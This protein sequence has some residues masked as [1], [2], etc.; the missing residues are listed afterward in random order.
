MVLLRP[1]PDEDYIFGWES[2]HSIN[3]AVL[4][5]PPDSPILTD[6]LALALSRPIVPPWFKRRLRVRQWGKW[7]FGRDTCLNAMPWGTIGPYALTHYAHKHGLAHK[8][9]PIEVFYPV[10][11][12]DAVVSL[13]DPVA[14]LKAITSNT[15]GVH[16]WHSKLALS[17]HLE[18]FEGCWLKEQCRRLGVADP[19][20][21]SELKRVA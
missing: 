20:W 9:K 2:G 16:L 5:L 7:L 3:N 15:I 19:R 8:A 4:R 18:P 17:Q 1:L 21:F 12:N 13:L 14:D 10:R 11:F 6:M